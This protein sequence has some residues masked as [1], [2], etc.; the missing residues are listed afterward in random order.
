M[1]NEV[2]AMLVI[3]VIIIIAQH[4]RIKRLKAPRPVKGLHL[5]DR[6]EI[7]KAWSK[8]VKYTYG[9]FEYKE[10][11]DLLE[12]LKDSQNKGSRVLILASGTDLNKSWIIY[13]NMQQNIL[14]TDK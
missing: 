2:L 8:P 3:Q 12:F 9:A 14:E 1:E 7:V 4:E 6:P 10:P 13:E 5:S 11:S